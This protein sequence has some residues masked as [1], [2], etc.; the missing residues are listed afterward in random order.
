MS[1]DCSCRDSSAGARSGQPLSRVIPILDGYLAELEKGKQ[2][3]A[4]LL[5]AQHP[6]LAGELRKYLD[7][8]EV[9]HQAATGL[10]DS[11]RS[12]EE[13]LPC[14]PGERGRLG[15]FRIIREIGRGGMGIVYE[16]EQL[17]LGRRVALKVLPFATA[18]DARQLQRFR[19][20][21]QAA[22]HLH[23]TNIV[24]VYF[25]GS[26]RGV[27]YY[28]MQFIEG[29]TVAAMI[30]E[31]RELAGKKFSPSGTPPTQSWPG[32]RGPEAV[33]VRNTTE[34]AAAAATRQ[35]ARQPAFFRTVAELGAQAAEAVEYAH[36]MG[37]VH[38]D[39]KPANLLIDARGHVW[40]TDF[41]L[42]LCQAEGGLTLTGDMIGTLRYMS[43]E[44]A[45]A[46][47]FLVD[48]R[49]DIYSLGVTLY[50]LLTLEPAYD[51]SDRQELL[52]QIAFEDPLP[53]RKLN[54]AVPSELET[55]VLKAMAKEIG[56]RYTSARELAEDLRSFLDNRPIRARRPSLRERLQKWE[57]R[58]RAAV[59]TATGVLT[60]V[61][62]GLLVSLLAIWQEKGRT[63]DA[64]QQ[65]NEQ[66]ILARTR[67]LEAR[68]EREHAE[69]N[70]G[71][72][73]AAV[74]QMLL[75]LDDS[76]WSRRPLD[77]E[78][79][80]QAMVRQVDEFFQSLLQQGMCDAT[81]RCE[82]SSVH[83]LMANVYRVHGQHD[84]AEEN[85]ERAIDLLQELVDQ[86][87]NDAVYQ[88]QLAMTYQ[89]LGTYL[90]TRKE[91]TERLAKLFN[92]AADHYRLAL[93]QRRDARTLGN[94]AWL[95]VS[96]P[97]PSFRDPKQGLELAKQAVALAP[98]SG[99]I[100]NTLGV[101][102]YRAGRWDDAM[103]ALKES[104][105]LRSGGDAFD[106]LVMAM[107]C[108]QRGN[109]READTWYEKADCERSKT[110]TYIEPVEP[111][112][113]EAALVLGKQPTTQKCSTGACDDDS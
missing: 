34:R 5:I 65:A 105:H 6:D 112:Y 17:S 22:A 108:K 41:G 84:K 73:K 111:F 113:R 64:L 27:H 13:P 4:E 75:K 19:N 28:A 1:S 30:T 24:P 51:G 89:A 53:P 86:F 2:P 16:A 47:R 21:A 50:E 54:P 40:I 80:R 72:M 99:E 66:A 106:W 49:T 63:L 110:N 38:R 58:H 93:E 43:P 46:K 14:A 8:L 109:G 100:Q 23:H 92:Q 71:V 56:G 26:D 59:I 102:Y 45:L 70:L 37:V 77:M 7:K 79:L 12:R 35:S 60:L 55:I 91:D 95:L 10:R 83:L 62:A 90:E 87:P 48:H 33:V 101:A 36:Q 78:K 103:A 39:I 32:E 82:A 42:A 76:R 15:D 68:S 3:D 67:A 104:M 11:F 57:S 98:Q 44:Q 107:A 69:K 96:C 52:R 88:G 31:L 29:R 61:V 74:T 85:Y 18:L 20:E 81:T 97:L 94:Y 25:V 9:L